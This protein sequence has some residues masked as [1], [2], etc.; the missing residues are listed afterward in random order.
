MASFL[1]HEKIKGEESF[2]F[3]YLDLIERSYTMLDWNEDDLKEVEDPV[4]HDEVYMIE[5]YIININYNF[6]I[7]A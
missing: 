2:Y 3:P 4:L 1:M 5:T 7:I 6:F